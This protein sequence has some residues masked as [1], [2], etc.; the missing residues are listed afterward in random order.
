MSGEAVPLVL[1][2]RYTSYVGD[3]TFTTVPLRVSEYAKAHITLWRGRLNFETF[4]AEFQVSHD[5]Y[6]WQNALSP[7][8]TITTVDTVD[9]WDIDLNH[10]WFRIKIVLSGDAITCWATGLLEKRVKEVSSVS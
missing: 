9:N 2:P 4:S 6:Q 5:T 7:P 3:N 1:I 8:T 10:R